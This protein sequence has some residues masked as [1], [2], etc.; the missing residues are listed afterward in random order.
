M[1]VQ[2]PATVAEGAVHDHPDAAYIKQDD[3][4]LVISKGLAVIYINLTT[5][6]EG[7]D[8]FSSV[9]GFIFHFYIII[10]DDKEII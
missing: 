7:N 2:P 10:N 6:K 9:V 4:G 3:L 8:S 1:S 5:A